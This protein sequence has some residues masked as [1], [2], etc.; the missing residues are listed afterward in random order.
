MAIADMTET[1]TATD[2]DV[3]KD[4]L[5]EDVGAL[6]PLTKVGALVLFP[7]DVVGTTGASETGAAVVASLDGAAGAEVDVTTGGVLAGAAVVVM[8]GIIMLGGK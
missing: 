2:E 1:S 6:V 4:R 3:M 8:V 5:T 7:L